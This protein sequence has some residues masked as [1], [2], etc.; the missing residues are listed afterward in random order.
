M[1]KYAMD[2]LHQIL[3]LNQYSLA[4]TVKK[5]K[6]FIE[7]FKI[8]HLNVASPDTLPPQKILKCITEMLTKHLVSKYCI[9]SKP[10]CNSVH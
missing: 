4:L 3:L 1:L 2:L 10:K 6:T 8:V 7:Y 9:E 5:K